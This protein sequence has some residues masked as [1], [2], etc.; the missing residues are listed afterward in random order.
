MLRDGAQSKHLLTGWEFV[1]KVNLIRKACKLQGGPAQLCSVT[2]ARTR[3]Y[4]HTVTHRHN[5]TQ[6]H[7]C[8]CV[9]AYIYV[10]ACIYVYTYSQK[11]ERTH[12]HT[13]SGAV[14]FVP[15]LYFRKFTRVVAFH[16]FRVYNR[17]VRWEGTSQRHKSTCDTLM[18]LNST[19]NSPV[20]AG[21][22]PQLL[23]NWIGKKTFQKVCLT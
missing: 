22:N 13:H 5:Q 19:K 11:Y 15:K 14:I 20:A 4:T 1:P 7:K 3:K 8:V 21:W 17:H 2:R 12:F 10:Y 9:C 23:A 16:L 18:L 6:T